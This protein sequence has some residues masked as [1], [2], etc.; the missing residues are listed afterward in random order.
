MQTDLHFGDL[1]ST[2]KNHAKGRKNS[3]KK[4]IGR[5]VIV[6]G[7]GVLGPS[8]RGEG[9]EGQS[10]APKKRAAKKEDRWKE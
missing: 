10:K 1:I 2:V 6:G 4:R 7:V 3:K 5:K 8:Q 9:A